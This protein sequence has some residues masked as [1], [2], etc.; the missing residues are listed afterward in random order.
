MQKKKN[1]ADIINDFFIINKKLI[2]KL[3]SLY[4]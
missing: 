1:N 2:V 3:N 4:R